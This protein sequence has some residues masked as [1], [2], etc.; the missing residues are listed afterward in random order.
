M[1]YTSTRANIDAGFVDTIAG[2][3]GQGGGLSLPTSWPRLKRGALVGIA[4]GGYG[5][6]IE[7]VG[8]AFAGESVPAAVWRRVAAETVAAFRHPAVA[9]LSEI[10]HGRWL[11]ELFHGPTLSFKDYGLQPLARLLTTVAPRNDSPLLILGATSGDTGSAGIAAFRGLP[12]ARIAILHPEGR[13]S[14]V[15]RLQMTTETAPNVLNIAVD[16]SFDDCQRIVKALLADPP[17]GDNQ[18]VLSVNSINWGRLVFQTAYYV[19]TAAR[20]APMGRPLGFSIPSGNF[21]NALSA[22]VA[23]KIGAPIDHLLIATNA[24]DALVR[25]LEGRPPATDGDVR[26]T[27]SPAMDIG[28]PSNLERLLYLLLDEDTAATTEATNALADALPVALPAN[29]QSRLPVSIEALRVTD[30]ETL[31]E[32][33]RSYRETDRILDPHSAVAVAAARRARR[34]R[35][36]RHVC[37]ATAH[38]GKF[39]EAVSRALGFTP[40]PPPPLAGLDR[41]R[42]HVLR[43]PAE[44]DAVRH[45]ILDHWQT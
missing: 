20:L 17:G 9:P 14:A 8:R 12:G 35:D 13:V 38:P 5:A 19:Y 31:G 4:E 28:I 23:A 11:L 26:A 18:P 21:G 29:W 45:L 40:P 22:I 32:I 10:G 16:G 30:A 1:R 44:T 33:R 27:H 34:L 24:N 15:Q 25:A 41:R 43:C 3:L 7:T 37:V 6:A 39:P 36:M 42:E 2:G